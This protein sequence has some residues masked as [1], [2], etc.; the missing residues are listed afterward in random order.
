MSSFIKIGR[1]RLSASPN[2]RDMSCSRRHVTNALAP[3]RREQRLRTPATVAPFAGAVAHPWAQASRSCRRFSAHRPSKG[4]FRSYSQRFS[5]KPKTMHELDQTTATKERAS[6]EPDRTPPWRATNKVM[7]YYDSHSFIDLEKEYRRP[8]GPEV[9]FHPSEPKFNREIHQT[10]GPLPLEGYTPDAESIKIFF[11]HNAWEYSME[12]S[13]LYLR[14]LCQCSKCVSP[15]TG[16]KTFATF[17]IPAVPRLR[18]PDTESIRLSADGGLEIT[19]EDD[20]LTGGRH[21]SV[22][23]GE[24]LTRLAKTDGHGMYRYAR[25]RRL[26]WDNDKFRHDMES[27]AITY[28]D[29]MEGGPEFAQAVLDLHEY[30]LVFMRGVPR[31][32]QSVERIAEK[33]GNLQSTIRGLTWD[34]ITQP[35]AEHVVGDNQ[36]IRLHQ[37]LLYCSH[38]PQVKFLHC[39]EN[40]CQGGVSLFSDGLHA[41]WELGRMD[42]PAYDTLTNQLITYAYQRAGHCLVKRRH[43]IQ[44]NQNRQPPSISWSPTFQGPFSISKHRKPVGPDPI[45]FDARKQAEAEPE[46]GALRVWCRAARA[47]AEI[48]ESPENVLQYRLQPGDC[49]IIDNT[50]IL[51]GRT[52]VDASVG[53]RHLRG[54]YVDSQA[55]H[56]TFVR[57]SEEGSLR[58]K[59]PISSPSPRRRRAGNAPSGSE[60][61]NS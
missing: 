49:V 60:L 3:L 20:F 28:R 18:D 11:K 50:R 59:E 6:P 25:P 8:V 2:P 23:S 19:W 54:A 35:E 5:Q 41:A 43:V 7:D 22:Y 13:K 33:M 57:I 47:F 10:Q 34:A 45:R 16:R 42:R 48:L 55:L 31:S 40:E 17:D 30:G 52:E 56:S 9:Q 29:W 51:H 12:L 61:E 53:L 27:R 38:P 32:R 39:L 58:R 21:T 4:F 26:L 15:S 24:F 1:P 14:D 44:S 37:D 46:R 36:R